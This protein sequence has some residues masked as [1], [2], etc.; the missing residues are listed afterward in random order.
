MNHEIQNILNRLRIELNNPLPGN[1]A[2]QKMIPVGRS[3]EP[4]P[5]IVKINKAG[6]LLLLFPEENELKTIFIRRPTSMKNHA[7]QIAF[8][9]GQFE[10]TDR[11]LMVTALREA[12][13]EI[14]INSDDVEIIGRLTPLYVR[15]SNFSIQTFIGWC[16]NTPFFKIDNSEVADIHILSVDTLINPDS[17]QIQKVN[18][19]F[20][21]T[22]FPGYL[23]ND[24][25]I[26]GATAM[27]LAE[28]VEVY[29]KVSTV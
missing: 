8:P 16:Q 4:L 23:V 11:N 2:H 5:G 12:V 9:G 26:W 19:T 18:T 24:V 28:F 14:G 10:P 25:F 15:V 17:L 27:I 13:E 7:G 6:V 29:R 20:G 3:L 21:I 22:E 1:T